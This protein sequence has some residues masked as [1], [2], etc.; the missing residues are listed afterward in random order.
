VEHDLQGFVLVSAVLEIV[1]TP[2]PQ[3][4]GGAGTPEA[5]RRGVRGLLLLPITWIVLAVIVVAPIAYVIV[6]SVLNDPT[7]LTAGFSLAAVRQ[8]ATPAMLLKLVKTV[9]FAVL[10]A[11]ITTVVGT[12]LAWS[13][14]RLAMRGERVREMFCVASLYMAPFITAV[15]WVWLATPSTGVI[16]RMMTSLHFPGWLEPNA[17]SV[18]G[19]VFVLVTHYVPYSFMFVSA[20]MRGLDSTLEEASQV[21]GRGRFF[22][23]MRI[24]IPMLRP[25]ILSSALF[26]AILAM[27]EFTVPSILG[28]AGAFT[29]LSVNVYN[30]IY[31]A[32]QQLSLGASISTELLVVCLIGLWLYQRSVRASSRFVSVGGKGRRDSRIEVR[33]LTA[34]LIWVATVVYALLAF[35]IPF[36]ALVLMS[37]SSFLA[38]S[39]SDMQLSFS[40]FWSTIDSPTVIDATINSLVLAIVIPIVCIVLGLVVVYVS[41]RLRMP[42]S[43]AMSY[44]ATA[45]MALPG[46]VLGMG[47]LLL[48]IHTPLYLTLGIIGV[49]LVSVSLTHAVRLISNGFRQIDAS[50]EEASQVSGASRLRTVVQILVPLIRPSIYAAYS[51]IFVLTI[52]ELNVP[53]VLYSPN[54]EVLA[55]AGWNYSE[56]AITQAAAIGVLQVVIM[57]AG[58]GVLRLVLNP[59]RRRSRS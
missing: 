36:F 58:M 38:P 22:T 11:A 27:G 43:G 53:I 9:G 5:D 18:S 4:Q 20:S 24:S 55:V 40:T 57:F 49:G 29:P 21:N 35:A 59:E 50:L 56:S 8:I 48:F 26:V 47:I 17:L 7:N 52:R 16:D 39:L 37:L 10:V 1:D 45:P 54:S 19:M 6:A 23:S 12:A 25:A 41:D 33:P 34:V 30:A 14:T 46:L 42:T 32:N 51:L 44:V 3:R 28:Q 13:T 15:A 31:G 2:A